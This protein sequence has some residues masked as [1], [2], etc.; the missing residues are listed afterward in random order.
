MAKKAFNSVST[1]SARENTVAPPT[2]PSGFLRDKRG[3]VIKTEEDFAMA[4][5]RLSDGRKA[6]YRA[7]K[8]IYVE[9]L[10]APDK[11]PQAQQRKKEELTQ[12]EDR[13][14]HAVKSGIEHKAR[15]L[16]L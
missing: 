6:R 8:P 4:E 12:N 10:A 5:H 15:K 9:P 11:H 13:R 14:H 7:G 3:R 1:P 16:Q 2:F